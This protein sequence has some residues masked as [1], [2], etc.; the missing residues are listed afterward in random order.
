MVCRL[1][2]RTMALSLSWISHLPECRVQ[3][4]H[5]VARVQDLRLRRQ[6]RR[7]QPLDLCRLLPQPLLHALNLQVEQVGLNECRF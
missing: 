6:A 3:A 1:S 7:L 5:L 4:L 2:N